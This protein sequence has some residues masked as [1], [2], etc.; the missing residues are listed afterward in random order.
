MELRRLPNES[1]D[2]V[3]QIDRSEVVD[4]A[5][6]INRRVLE[7]YPVHWEIPSFHPDGAGAHS[8]EAH[9]RH[10]SKV[11]AAGGI[12]LGAFEDVAV[13]GLAIVDP[14]FEPPMA[15]LAFMHVSRPFR[16]RGVG[17]WL[18]DEAEGIAQAHGARSIY[19]SAIPSGPAIDFY[20]ARGCAPVATLH[21]RLFA[22]EPD[23]LHLVKQLD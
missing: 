14:E 22:E 2:L 3:A 7:R 8:V 4:Y 6:R 18:W 11:L 16:R 5:Y 10:W 17:R 19:V 23:D 21:P 9:V 1:I 20:I 12:L 13:A 15:R